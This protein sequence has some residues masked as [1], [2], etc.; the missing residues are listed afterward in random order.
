MEG[1]VVVFV[2]VNAA[3]R[4]TGR[5]N[6]SV[7]LA[8]AGV[9][10]AGFVGVPPPEH[11]A[12]V[13]VSAVRLAAASSPLAAQ[14]AALDQF[15]SGMA[16]LGGGA[17]AVPAASPSG[18]PSSVGG[19]ATPMPLAAAST[20]PT[21]PTPLAATP[22]PLAGIPA[23]SDIG[24]AIASAFW[25][26][27][28]PFVN[29]AVV[30]PFVLFGGILFGIFVVAPIMYVVETVQQFFAPLLNL[31]PLAASPAAAKTGVP[32]AAVQDP[33]AAVQD[34][35]PTTGSGAVKASAKAPGGFMPKRQKSTDAISTAAAVDGTGKGKAIGIPKLS[36]LTA[37]GGQGN[38]G[39]KNVGAGQAGTGK[40]DTGKSLS[41]NTKSS[42]G[43]KSGNGGQSG[44]SNKD[45]S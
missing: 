9:V 16:Q 20:T 1:V 17:A 8:G 29:N 7:A 42:R 39:G 2:S 33:V 43:D 32:T 31:L 11:V 45:G 3:S 36:Q 40:S 12:K 23:I 34:P 25:S 24:S 13:D 10:V 44:N 22:T 35:A 27:V 15:I 19:S 18:G 5:L 6:V 38:D 30:G 41:H 14:W 28:G 21:G 26:L 4:C 37:P